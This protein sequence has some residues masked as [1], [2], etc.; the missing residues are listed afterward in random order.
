MAFIDTNTGFNFASFCQTVNLHPVCRSHKS[1]NRLKLHLKNFVSLDAAIHNG[2]IISHGAFLKVFRSRGRLSW[3]E[4][5]ERILKLSLW[6]FLGASG[7]AQGEVQ[8]RSLLDLPSGADQCSR[9]PPTSLYDSTGRIGKLADR[10][11]ESQWRRNGARRTLDALSNQPATLVMP[12]IAAATSPWYGV[13]RA[14]L[15]TVAWP[16][17]G[18]A[19]P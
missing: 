3:G 14:R 19:C 12:Y 11:E 13:M 6:G 4:K 9:H 10:I 7:L 18:T 2:S 8:N 1:G 15:P 17:C 5:R 16:C